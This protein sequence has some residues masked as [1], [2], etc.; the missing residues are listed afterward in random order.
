[1][2]KY[3]NLHYNYKQVQPLTLRPTMNGVA[4]CVLVHNSGGASCP[5]LSLKMQLATCVQM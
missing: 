4:Q 2:H 5:I 1:M 3:D